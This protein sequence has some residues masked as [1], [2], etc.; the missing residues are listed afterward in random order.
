MIASPWDLLGC[1]IDSRYKSPIRYL[2]HSYYEPQG[3][4]LPHPKVHR[5]T[6]IIADAIRLSEQL[7]GAPLAHFA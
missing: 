5:V 3:E 1:S 2:Y 7:R 4:G 6:G